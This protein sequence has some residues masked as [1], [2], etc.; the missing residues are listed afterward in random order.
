MPYELDAAQIEEIN[1]KL[2]PQFA[3]LKDKY[4]LTICNVAEFWDLSGYPEGYIPEWIDIYYK[5]EPTMQADISIRDGQLTYVELED[6]VTDPSLIYMTIEDDPAYVQIEGKV[7]V[8]R[9]KGVVLPDALVNSEVML[10][11]I[12]SGIAAQ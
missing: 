8:N 9:L 3:A 11:S 2:P 7:I 12:L 1:S 6:P 5:D 10:R 4:P